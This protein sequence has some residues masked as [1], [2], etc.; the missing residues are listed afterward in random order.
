MDFSDQ[1]STNHGPTTIQQLIA[2]LA[3]I[4]ERVAPKIRHTIQIQIGNALFLKTTENNGHRKITHI[5]AK[6]NQ[7]TN[8]FS[9]CAHLAALHLGE[10]QANVHW[11]QTNQVALCDGSRTPP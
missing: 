10:D 11:I 8:I 2:H 6:Y 3:F 1:L 9:S 7:S 5:Q 4:G